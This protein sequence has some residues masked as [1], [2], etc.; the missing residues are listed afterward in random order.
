[1]GVTSLVEFRILGPLEIVERDR[2]VSVGAPKVRALLAVLLLHRGEVVSTD[3]LIDAL[4]GERA[5]ATAA[6]TVQVY[7]SNLRKALGDGLLVTRGHGYLLRVASGQV[8]LDRFDALSADGRRALHAGDPQVARDRLRDAL[9]LWR[10]P[11]LEDF[12]YEPFAQSDIA[13]LEEARLEALEDRIDADL[14]AGEQ[15]GL[16]GELEALVAEHPVRERLQGQLMLALYRS[17]R[18]ADALEHYRMARESMIEELG[19]EPGPGLQE[20]ERA[21][22]SQDPELLASSRASG[23]SRSEAATVAPH[24]RRGAWLIVAAGAILLAALAAAVLK[25][26][27]SGTASVHVPANSLAAIDP[28]S[29]SVVQSAPVGTGPGPVAFGFG[30]IWVANLDDQTVSR[31]DPGSLRTLRVLSLLA[32]PTGMAAGA[33]AVWVAESDPTASSVSVSAIDPQFDSLRLAKRFGNVVPGGPGAVATQGSSVWVAPSSGELTRFN[34]VTG[35]VAQPLDPNAGPTAIAVGGDGAIWLTDNEADNVVRVDPTGLV[36]PIAVG[37]GPIGIAVGEGA[38]WVA[39]SLD[40]KV[41]RIDP[42]SQS[43]TMTI[44]VGR[45]PTGVAIGAGSVWVAN[46]GDG[47]VTRIDPGTDRVVATIALGGSPQAITV[48]DG[49]VWVTVDAQTVPSTD[50]ASGGGTLRM[51]SQLDPKY[52]D[53]ALAGLPPSWQLLYAMCA[54]LVNYPD[55]S[56]PAGSRLI[57]EVARSLPVRSADGKTYTFTIRGG[58]RFSPPSNEPVNAQTFKYAIERSLGPH[59]GAANASQ[60]ADVVGEAAYTA[61]KAP[62]ISGVTARGDTLTIRLRAP[63]PNLPARLSQPAFCAVPTDTPIDPNGVRALSSAGPYYLASYTPGQ[64]IV[65]KR[66]PNYR[67]SRPH[68]FARIEVATGVPYGRAVADVEAGTAGYT[69][70]IGPGVSNVRTFTYQLAA[71]YGPGSQAARDGEQQYFSNPQPEVGYFALNTHRP[72]FADVRMR[73]AVGYAVNRRTLAQLGEP[74]VPLP[75]SPTD[76]YLPPGMPGH[77]DANVYPLTPDLRKAHALAHGG[78]RTAVL[79][80]CDIPSCAQQ[81]EILKTELAAIGLRVQVKKFPVVAMWARL[82][83][84]GEP[85]DITTFGWVSGYPDPAGMLSDMLEGGAPYPTYDDPIWRRRLAAAAQLTGPGRYLAYGKLDLDLARNAAPLIAFGNA[86]SSDF[87]STR[88]GCE[89]Y[90]VYGM[91]LAALCVRPGAR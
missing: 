51:E 53:P 50:L 17:G 49:R 43:V 13:R 15:A 79:Y 62:H 85:F 29:N 27:G 41:V 57:P 8:D 42:T 4:W 7:V 88:I 5:P 54:K 83:K 68:W 28:R 34:S 56:G 31:V 3:R 77:S 33:G 44:R 86:I 81:A 90:G 10:G 32:P 66:N 1:M 46:S 76:H 38:V 35:Q 37:N 84:P 75:E 19:L 58:F 72:L 87:F 60:L 2:P 91:D 89:T 24:R 73:Q 25:L 26:S 80:T 6:K 82:A 74:Y 45:S 21:I 63:A 22:L 30:S 71:R 11:P 16:V 64:G 39:D 23:A 36:T 52:M 9:A 67:G 55:E 48:A 12:A 61:G 47:T 40:D 20:L 18:Q 65:L 59:M 70:L 14:A 78:S 69:A